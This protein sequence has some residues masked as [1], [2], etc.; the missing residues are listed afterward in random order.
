[1]VTKKRTLEDPFPKRILLSF[2]KGL[3]IFTLILCVFPVKVLSQGVEKP[4]LVE[5]WEYPG[6]DP[7]LWGSLYAASDGRV[8]TGLCT[9]G[10]SSHFYQ[11][12]PYKDIHRNVCDMAEFLG[13]RG[14][15]IRGSSKIHTRP[16][17]D[18]DGNIYFCTM[19]NGSGPRNIDY[20]S[21]PGGRWMK[22]D[23]KADKMEDL[24]FV[25]ECLGCYGFTIDKERKY[26]F[27]TAYTSYLYR[28]DIEERISTCLGRIDNWDICRQ[29][30]CDDE[31]NVYGAFPVARMWK[32]DAKKEKV[33]DLSVKIPFNPRIFPTQLRNPML[34]RSTIWRGVVWDPVDNV[35][36]GVTCGSGSILFKYDPHNGPEGKVTE[37]GRLCDSKFLESADR[38]D[39]P[40]SPLTLCLDSKNRKIYFIPS[41][42]EYT[43]ERY[44]ETLGSEEHHHLIMYDLKANKRVD[45]GP[46]QTVDGRWVH[47]C[48]AASCDPNGNVYICGQ[49]RV[50][51]PEKATR[52]IRGVSVAIHLLKYKP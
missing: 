3:F 13:E 47:G 21:Y 51:D 40:Y 6:K 30:V 36:Y 18:N 25:D 33:Y 17:E 7:A 23:P 15:G 48:E 2:F 35:F 34:D 10:G 29:I 42:R 44:V 38:Q 45:L 52:N 41:A 20:T 12:D 14:R 43:I 5:V 11:Y 37:L 16:C 9:E 46:L 4:C 24:G 1:M 26:L 8:Y 49:V 22:F 32:Y 28:F 19:N 27:G 31:G 50:K 39:I